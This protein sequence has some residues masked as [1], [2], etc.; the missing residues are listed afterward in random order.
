MDRA[1]IPTCHE[2]HYIGSEFVDGV[3]RP[4]DRREWGEWS[5]QA[6]PHLRSIGADV[7]LHQVRHPLAV[8]AS[9][10]RFGLFSHPGWFGAQGRAIFDHFAATGSPLLDA[11]RFYVE[12]NR[13]CAAHADLWWRV[14]N[15]DATVL[16][17]IGDVVGA[18]VDVD[19]ALAVPA[20]ANTRGPTS[21][22]RWS[23]LPD[24]AAT[25]EL[26]EMARSYGYDPEVGCG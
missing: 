2:Q 9:Y 14:E 21:T 22:V 26:I 17:R 20:G 4:W 12:W 18:D 19:A 1:G 25:T 23:D 15:V 8:I 16:R 13:R 3:P 24:D 6:V 7:V 10:L 11:V 5:A